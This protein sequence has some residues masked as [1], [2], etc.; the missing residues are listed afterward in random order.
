MLIYLILFWV[1]QRMK[2]T[3]RYTDRIMKRYRDDGLE[4]AVRYGCDLFG[5]QPAY[6]K[7]IINT[8]PLRLRVS[9]EKVRTVAVEIR[10]AKNEQTKRT[11]AEAGSRTGN[12]N[13]KKNVLPKSCWMTW[14]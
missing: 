5:C 10:N 2:D 11:T 3:Q 8:L 13:L 9:I 12:N 14:V 4:A 6:C 7:A 1:P